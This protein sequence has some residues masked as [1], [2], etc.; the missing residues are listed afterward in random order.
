MVPPLVQFHVLVFLFALTGILGPLMQIEAP[1]VVLWRTL[2]SGLLMAAWFAC[3]RPRLLRLPFADLAKALGIGAI[4]G[5]HWICFFSAIELS[6]VSVALS[7]FAAISLFTSFTEPLLNRTPFQAS[8]LVL[9]FVVAAGLGLIVGL[10]FAHALGLLVGL[11]GAFLAA[12]FPVLNHR[13]VNR[14]LPSRTL[15]VYEMAGA[16][17]VS[18]LYLALV[19][20]VGFRFPS[21]GDWPP[22]LVLILVCTVFSQTY[23]LHLLRRLTAFTTNLAMNFEPIY[24]ILMA[25]LFYHEYEELHPGFYLGA[26]AIIAAN[27][28]EA[29]LERR[30]KKRLVVA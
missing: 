3:T 7:A 4:I 19:P 15:M 11:L 8:Q 22:L 12:V 9:G 25:A 24:A 30:K 27:L 10:E 20:G 5:L 2:V 13:L 18:A 16:A 29:A 28:T 1:V 23:Y 14:G 6:N 21:A 26:L 17:L